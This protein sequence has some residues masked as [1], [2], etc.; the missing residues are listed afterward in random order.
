MSEGPDSRRVRLEATQQ[1]VAFFETL[2]SASADGIVI[3][4]GS[5]NIIIVNEAFC[6]F[7]EKPLRDVKDTSLFTWLEQLDPG[8]PQRWTELEKRIRLQKVCRNI[9]FQLNTK[10][11]VRYLS[12]NASLMKQQ[13]VD[14]H[15]IIISIWCDITRQKQ[16]EIALQQAHDHLEQRIRERTE[17]L[18]ETNEKLSQ[19]IQVSKKS[20]QALKQ[21]EEKYRTIFENLQ[22]VYFE[23]LVNGT[24]LEVS[25]SVELISQYSRQEIL[26]T[27]AWDFYANPKERKYLL[28]KIKQ[29]GKI[30]DYEIHLKDK[31]GTIIPCSIT[32]QLHIDISGKPQK[33]C[34]ILR[35][36]RDRKRTE[37]ERQKFEEQLRHA[38]KM[39]AI[40]SLAGGIA[41]DFNNILGI[42]MGYVELTR[43]DILEDNLMRQNLDQV[44]AAANRAKDL[45]NQILAFSRKDE[46]ERKPL[47][48]NE[49]I[50]EAVQLLKA[51]IPST[52]EIRTHIRE[53]LKPILANSS[54]IH[55]VIMNICTNAAYAMKE[56]GGILKIILKEINLEPNGISPN[57]LKPG[58]YQQLT[59]TDTGKGMSHEVKNRIFEPYFTTKRAGEGTGLGLAVFHGIVKSHRGKITVDSQLKKGT[60]VHIFLPVIEE[61]TVPAEEEKGEI[62]SGNE[63]ILFIDNNHSLAEIGKQMLEKLGYKVETQTGSERV[64]E[65]FREAPNHYDLVITAYTMPKMTGLQMT[66]ELK[67]IRPDIPVILVTGFS[68]MVN[69]ENFKSHGIDAFVM[70]PIISKDIARVIRSVLDKE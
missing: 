58:R 13:P 15:S 45:V 44:L 36:I 70:K 37:A 2:L 11:G 56:K 60:S 5:Q 22:D 6:S 31:D 35:D 18:I 33:M 4:G 21:S 24:I 3:T 7:F 43:D 53:K 59:F 30:T 38:Q 57:A 14:G 51:T 66:R 12:V 29:T 23:A 62:P 19:E 64:L 10:E 32:A 52:I 68:E 48:L 55:Q 61:K 42:I 25:P 50:S 41:H 49:I 54:Q 9:P 17:V 20:E 28:E 69:Q 16:A 1:T 65:M 27:P 26:C 40:G 34:G 47:Y 46:Q 8:A 63:R 39:E 67:R